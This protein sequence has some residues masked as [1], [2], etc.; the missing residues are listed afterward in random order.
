M[1]KRTLTILLFLLTLIF[2]TAICYAAPAAPNA[3]TNF[4]SGYVW[5]DANNNGIQELAEATIA[6]AIV[7][8]Q[9]EAHGAIITVATEPSGSFVVPALDNGRYLVWCEYNGITTEAQAIE[10]AELMGAAT[11]GIPVYSSS[12]LSVTAAAPMPVDGMMPEQNEQDLSTIYLPVI[13]H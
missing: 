7:Y 12:N 6:N 10:V 11:I 4:L 1:P 3:H 13:L 9:S 2:N 5:D 8:I